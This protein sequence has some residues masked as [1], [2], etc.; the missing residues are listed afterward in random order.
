[1]RN[2]IT[3]I[4]KIATDATAKLKQDLRDGVA[5][6]LLEV[7]RLRNV[8]LEVGQELGRFE[9]IV[10]GNEW[11]QSLVA[12]VRGDS[13]VNASQV[14]VVGLSVL[15]GVQRWIE[16]NQNDIQLSYGLKVRVGSVIQ[17][18]EQWRV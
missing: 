3:A 2:E 12:L 9:T 6:T 5:E 10:E 14:R 8:S 17:E 16:R 11:L 15:R 4:A 13:S 1:M 18:F 7:E